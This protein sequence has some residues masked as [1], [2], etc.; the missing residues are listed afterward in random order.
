MGKEASR[1]AGGE[2]HGQG[3]RRRGWG[4]VE[5]L[6]PTG[7]HPCSNFLRL[8]QASALPVCTQS[9][10]G[11]PRTQRGGYMLYTTSL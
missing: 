10:P 7:L 9:H 4:L 3:A 1:L 11:R 2:P 5:Y 8:N 6:V